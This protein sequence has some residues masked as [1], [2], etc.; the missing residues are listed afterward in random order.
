MNDR[1]WPKAAGQSTTIERPV[2]V[3]AAVEITNATSTDSEWP[4]T[5]RK[6]PVAIG[7]YSGR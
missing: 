1:F 3:K 5:T 2:S 6:Q 4:V 7:I